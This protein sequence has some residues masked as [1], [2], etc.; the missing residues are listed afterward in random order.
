MD[1]SKE[2]MIDIIECECMRNDSC[3]VDDCHNCQDLYDC[4]VKTNNECNH[5][6]AKS[7]GYGGYDSE[8]E[9]WENLD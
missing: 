2:E 8:E 7:I 3:E 1:I 9:F 4:Y 6:F 5:G